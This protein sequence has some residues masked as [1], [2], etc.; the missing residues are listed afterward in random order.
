MDTIKIVCQ[1]GNEICEGCGPDRDCGLE[2]QDCDR[3]DSALEILEKY[4]NSVIEESK[5]PDPF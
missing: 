5:K 3:I 1:I 2:Y 4:E